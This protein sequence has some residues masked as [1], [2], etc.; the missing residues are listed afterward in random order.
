MPAT[1][2]PPPLMRVALRFAARLH[3][4]ADEPQ[5]ST[6]VPDE[7]WREARERTDR[8]A[9]VADRLLRPAAPQP[10][11]VERRLVPAS[12]GGRVPIRVL[13]PRAPSRLPPPVWLY[14]HGGGWV[15]GSAEV[16]DRL[17]RLLAS[18]AGCAVVAVDYRLAPE[19]PF[20]RPLED[21]YDVAQWL[22]SHGATLGL[23][24]REL[25]VGGDSAGGNLA[26]ALC[27][28]ARDR[29]GPPIAQQTLLFPALD[30]TL[31]QASLAELANGYLLTRADMERFVGA[32]LQ[33]ADPRDTRA[34]PLHAPELR[35]LPPALVITAGCDPLRDEGDAYAARLREASVGVTHLRYPR[36]LHGFTHGLPR[37]VP[38]VAHAHD[39]VTAALRRAFASPAPSADT[40]G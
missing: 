29:D 20:P 13:V 17:Q 36:M 22:T 12:D 19:H 39:A 38:E 27:L 10:V 35:G 18:A 6:V 25:A 33:G 30:L 26:A 5:R 3:A 31:E 16:T 14:L 1:C 4:V 7:R 15:L 34:S 40:L 9:R 2:Q 8:A 11:R 23:D 24:T 32:Y 28:L 37:A 21:A